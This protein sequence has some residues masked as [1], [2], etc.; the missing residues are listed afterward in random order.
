[1]MI[2]LGAIALAFGLI[3]ALLFP[4]PES[5]RYLLSKGRDAEAVEAVNYVA[6]YNGRPETLTLAMVQAID[7][8]LRGSTAELE[9]SPGPGGTEPPPP[10]TKKEEEEA[11]EGEEKPRRLSYADLVRASFRDY[12]TGNVRRL[13]AGRRMAQHTRPSA[14]SFGS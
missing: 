10:P 6:R 9:S 8:S 5:P 1:M 2:T 11:G 4:I 12:Q 3:R 13:F 7:A 14:S